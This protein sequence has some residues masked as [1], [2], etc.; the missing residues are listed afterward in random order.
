MIVKNI[1]FNRW[2]KKTGSGVYAVSD[3][4]IPFMGINIVHTSGL[5]ILITDILE[6]TE[7]LIK[8]GGR[9]EKLVYVGKLIDVAPI[10]VRSN[11]YVIELGYGVADK[12]AIVTVADSSDRAVTN[13]RS[14]IPPNFVSGLKIFSSISLGSYYTLDLRSAVWPS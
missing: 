2:L 4:I 7:R 14:M 8:C 6:F 11:M 5:Y 12:Y 13:I 9:A 1:K 3:L 10:N